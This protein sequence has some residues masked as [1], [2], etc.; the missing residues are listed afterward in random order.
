MRAQ[1]PGA[2]VVPWSRKHL[3]DLQSVSEWGAGGRAL[4]LGQK[5]ALRR[6]EKSVH[7]AE[8]VSAPAA[9]HPSPGT[10]RLEG[11]SPE[12][13]GELPLTHPPGTRAWASRPL[14]GVTWSEETVPGL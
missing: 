4:A 7:N 14:P 10:G 12:K 13:G 2:A 9:T 11:S 3:K 1:W 5:A 8:G 6:E